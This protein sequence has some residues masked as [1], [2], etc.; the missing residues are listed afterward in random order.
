MTF[1]PLRPLFILLTS[2]VLTGMAAQAQDYQLMLQLY[3]D[4]SDPVSFNV[5]DGLKWTLQ[6]TT[7]SITSTSDPMPRTFDILDVK[8]INYA[9]TTGIGST[10][11]D[12]T[13]GIMLSV[14][15]LT[16]TLEGVKEGAILTVA[17]LSGRV[18][19]NTTSAGKTSLELPAEGAYI[20]SVSGSTTFKINVR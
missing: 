8:S 7:L 10:V 1:N 6:G 9:K 13:Q 3:G 19:H 11:S 15:E 12:K 17:D 18:I 2:L 5:N 14:S 16:V 20:V 4:D